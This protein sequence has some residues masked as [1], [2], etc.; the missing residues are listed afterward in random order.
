MRTPPLPVGERDGVRGGTSSTDKV[1]L[2]EMKS[3][4]ITECEVEN[5]KVPFRN[6]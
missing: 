5:S 1:L 4:G 2:E 3:N 6:W